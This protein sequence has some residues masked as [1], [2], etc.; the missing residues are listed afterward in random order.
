[1]R[2]EINRTEQIFKNAI[3]LHCPH[4]FNIAYDDRALYYNDYSLYSYTFLLNYFAQLCWILYYND[5]IFHLDRNIN[6]CSSK[7]N[8]NIEIIGRDMTYLSFFQ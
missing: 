4:Q 3:C 6:I 8:T 7:V 5:Q 1:M 2:I